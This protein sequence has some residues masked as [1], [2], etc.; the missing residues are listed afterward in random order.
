MSSSQA[1]SQAA[2]ATAMAKKTIS[3]EE[4]SA[5]LAEIH[6]DREDL[7]KLIMNYL[8][9]EGYKD[10]AEKFSQESGAKP[11]VNLESIQ[12]RMVVRTAIQRGNIEEAIE[13]VN[14]LNPEILD[15]NPKLFF[16]L[17]QQRLIEFIREG[18]IM[19][20][21]EFAQEELAPRGEE[22]PEFLAELERTMSLLAF[23]LNGPS[24]VS[25]L[26]TPAQRQKLASELNS[27]L[28]LSQSQEKDPKLPALLKMCWYAQQQ[29]DERCTY[30]KIKDFT[31]AELVMEPMGSGPIGGGSGSGTVAGV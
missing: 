22:N 24:P 1:S 10:A 20:A 8:I 29:L 17:Q 3:K 19:E 23:E 2:N 21:L 18:Q 7:N 16:H 11:P 25:D 26:L 12:D 14:D 9:I 28:L 6:V 4:W 31:K 27:A 15:T 5:Q 13:R 30:P